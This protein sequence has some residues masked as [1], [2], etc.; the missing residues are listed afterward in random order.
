VNLLFLVEGAITED[1]TYRAWISHL[2]PHLNF[3]AKPEDAITNSYRIIRGNGYPSIF[4]AS[5]IYGS[6]SPLEACLNDINNYNNIDHFFICLDVEED[7]YQT[8]F[9]EI[10]DRLESLKIRVGI[11]PSQL[12]KFH[13]IIQNC[14]VETWFLGN[15]EI[16]NKNA[17][18]KR[19][20]FSD[21]QTH[22]NI[23]LNDPE[24]MIDH[25]PNHYHR[26]KAKFHKAYLKE[27]LEE[28]GLRYIQ[29]N[30]TLITEKEYLEALIERCKLTN[31]LSSLKYLLNIWEEMQNI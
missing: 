13:I 22:Y 20:K 12:T 14:C 6:I 9:D 24:L 8:R 2:F 19:K 30:P 5:K 28:F 26:T 11:E 27:Y 15:A 29:S 23:L 31:H 4:S 7:T 18:K 10:K 21:F 1:R 25:P 3:A 16:S 17:P